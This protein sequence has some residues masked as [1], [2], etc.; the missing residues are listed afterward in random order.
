MLTFPAPLA[1]DVTTTLRQA[2][3]RFSKVLQHWEG[4]AR[5]EDAEQ[6]RPGA[7]WYGAACCHGPCP[8]LPGTGAAGSGR[9]IARNR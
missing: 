7:G 8:P 5:L 3:F 1:K 4:L 2:G 6:P 9:V